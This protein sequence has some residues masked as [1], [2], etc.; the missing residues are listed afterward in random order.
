[1][2]EQSRSDR[3][4]Y[5]K[6]NFDNVEPGKEHNFRVC[7]GCDLQDLQYDIGSIM[8]YHQFSFTVDNSI[9]TIEALDGTSGDLMGQRSG[10][11]PMDIEGINKVYCGEYIIVWNLNHEYHYLKKW[12]F[13]SLWLINNAVFLLEC[14]ADSDCS[15][16]KTCNGGVCGGMSNIC[17]NL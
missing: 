15:G 9:P 7:Q 8:H 3:D 14:A 12:A 2:H 11:S 6:I 5:V 16:S 4:Q 10:F 17:M 1:M 13:T